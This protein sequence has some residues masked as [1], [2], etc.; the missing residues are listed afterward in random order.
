MH[1]PILEEIWRVRAE[2][3]RK[4]GGFDGLLKEIQKVE[5]A[6]RGR[7]KNQ[8]EKKRSPTADDLKPNGRRQPQPVRPDPILD[9]AK[10]GGQHVRDYLRNTLE[11]SNPVIDKVAVILFRS[12]Y[13]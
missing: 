6:H 5:R 11:F 10:F 3:I 9:E 7:R 12:K 1:D 4:H 8:G 2:L 13:V